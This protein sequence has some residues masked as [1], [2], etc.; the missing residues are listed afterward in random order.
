MSRTGAC[1]EC[2]R[3][4]WLLTRLAGH[5]DVERERMS[6]LLDRADED[7]IEAVGG[8]HVAKVRAEWEAF[9]ADAIPRAVR[10]RR[11]RDAVSV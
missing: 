6:E 8:S 10:R 3:R 7:L 11:C 4:A 1:A 9:D 5:L 2:L